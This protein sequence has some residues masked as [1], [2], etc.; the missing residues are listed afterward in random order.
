MEQFFVFIGFTVTIVVILFLP[1]LIEL[2]KPKDVGPRKIVGFET[3]LIQA[4]KELVS[5]KQPVNSLSVV[6]SL[7]DLEVNSSIS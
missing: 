7:S 6:E 3:L 2:K 4:E 5:S 1:A